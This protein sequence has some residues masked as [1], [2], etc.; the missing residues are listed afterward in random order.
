MSVYNVIFLTFCPDWLKLGRTNE[1][2]Y[3]VF[4]ELRMFNNVD[5]IIETM[6]YFSSFPNLIQ[7]IEP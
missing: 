5:V 1:N 2:K 4:P 6:T 7:I 3:K